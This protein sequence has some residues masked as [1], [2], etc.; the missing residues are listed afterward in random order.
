MTDES[1]VLF[2]AHTGQVSGAEK[3]LLDLIDEAE[4]SGH[5]TVIACPAGPLAD[6]LPRTTR[7]I[8]IDELGLGGERGAARVI[9][10]VRMLGRWV[11]GARAIRTVA[12]APGTATVVNS[13]FALPMARFARPTRGASWLVHDT[14][15][16]L[17]QRLVVRFARPA[18]RVAVS[19]SEATAEPLRAAG[20]PVVVSH[21][22]VPWPV[23]RFGGELHSPPVVGMLALLTPW[24]GHRVLL[25]AIAALPDIRVELAGGSFPGDSE[26]VAELRERAGRPDLLGRVEFLGH[27]DAESA[28]RR[29]DV[30]VSASV[31]PE[32]GPLSVLEAMSHGLPVIGTDHGGTREF[33]SDGA[34]ILVE[35]GN[36]TALADAI[37]TVLG[38]A[39]GRRTLGETARYRVASRHDIGETLPALLHR[40]IA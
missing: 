34:G 35:P 13:L 2:L 22:G 33:L 29:W 4:R 12:R 36:A 14:M 7:H 16:S 38:D 28:L 31:S 11:T 25:D 19:V 24:K 3:V 5:D 32:A 20:L 8:R 18:V 26:Y 39:R 30:F 1:T 27:T 17:K 15:T 40:L 10:A 23:P 21:N 37:S 6:R 9:A